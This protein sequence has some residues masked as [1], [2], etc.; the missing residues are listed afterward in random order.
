MKYPRLFLTALLLSA[1]AGGVLSAPA[2][3]ND[4]IVHAF[5]RQQLTDVY[6]SEGV[7]AG[8]L[9]RD[10]H[11]DIVHG[12]YWFAGP[13]LTT[14]HEIYP[15]RA[16]PRNRYADNFFSWVYDFN[17][18]GWNDVLVVGFP[19]SQRCDSLTKHTSQILGIGRII[20][21]A[22]RVAFAITGKLFWINREEQDLVSEHE[23]MNE[24]SAGLFQHDRDRLPISEC[25]HL[26]D[27]SLDFLRRVLEFLVESFAVAIDDI[28]IMFLVGPVDAD[29][30][31]RLRLL[32]VHAPT[33]FYGDVYR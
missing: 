18:D 19:N 26:C 31:A 23:S 29:E 22:T 9:N 27:P 16:Q 14:K 24:R 4:R 7:A 32:F 15:P 20:L 3:A 8:D 11:P 5:H 13:A 10:G 17:R 33:P 2:F 12:P 28:A 25:Q 1:G 21:S 30:E 6:Y